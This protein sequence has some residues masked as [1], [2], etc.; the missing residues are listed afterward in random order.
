MISFTASAPPPVIPQQTSKTYL[1]FCE[2]ELSPGKIDAF[3][4]ASQCWKATAIIA[5][6]ML[7]ILVA[8]AFVLVILFAP[9]VFPISVAGVCALFLLWGVKEV[10]SYCDMKSQ[11]NSDRA[12][13]L[14]AIEKH[15]QTLSNATP[16]RIQSVL[17]QKG[18]SYVTGMGANS[19]RLITL[20]PLIARHLFWEDRM[21]E[22]EKKQNEKAAAAAKLSKAN[23]VANR[24]HI[25]ALQ[26]EAVGLEAETLKAKVKCAFVHAVLRKPEFKG[27]FE[28]LG[29]FSH[30]SGQERTMALAAKTPGADDFFIFNGP[31][32]KKIT[33][34]EAKT[35][36]ISQLAIL[37]MP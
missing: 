23:S 22:L 28:K 36:T 19:P 7:S 16:E 34:S 27:S 31:N 4:I 21:K 11:L 35:F 5:A 17:S 1:Q 30:L 10:Y 32:A 8:S 13:Q 29:K 9:L 2:E 12:Q 20:K 26:S 3:G 37:K 14:R 25:Y 33:L 15:H 18:I 6:T 24:D